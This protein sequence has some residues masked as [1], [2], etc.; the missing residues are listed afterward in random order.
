MS[1]NE[2][3]SDDELVLEE[4][5]FSPYEMYTAAINSKNLNDFTRHLQGKLLTIIDASISDKDQC[6]AIK[7]LISEKLWESNHTVQ[8]W[9]FEQEGGKES[10]FPY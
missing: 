8:E 6:K 9:M 2:K 1:E 3:V 7:S 10:S 4:G 5:A